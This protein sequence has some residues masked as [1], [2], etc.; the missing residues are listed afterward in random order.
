ME[1]IFS[2]DYIRLGTLGT[3]LTGNPLPE[4]QLPSCVTIPFLGN[5]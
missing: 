2:G 1:G 3:A 5:P 4:A